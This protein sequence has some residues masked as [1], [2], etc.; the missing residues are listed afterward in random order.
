MAAAS[1][2]SYRLPADSRQIQVEITLDQ[3]DTNLIDKG[4][5]HAYQ[6]GQVCKYTGPIT[7]LIL[8]EN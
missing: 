7:S 3:E 8:E 5:L 2:L 6:P 4:K 1:V